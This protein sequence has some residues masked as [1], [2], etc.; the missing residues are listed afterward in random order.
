MLRLLRLITG[1]QVLLITALHL[2]RAGDS[3]S[4]VAASNPTAASTPLPAELQAELD[5]LARA[6][7]HPSASARASI[8]WRDNVLLSPFA[9]IERGFARG[10]LEAI[11]L[12]PMRD[13][14][15]FISFLNGDV[16][17]YFTPPSET[18]G[19]QQWSLHTEGR[20]QP[21]TAARLALKGATYLRDMVIDLSETEGS[22]VV[23]PTHVRGGYAIAATRLT[24]G[25]VQ[26]EPSVQVKRT[27]YR[28]YSGDYDEVRSGARLEWKPS[29]AFAISAAWFEGRRS[30]DERVEYNAGGR[31]LPG[32]HLRFRQR[33]AE[34]KVR[35]AW[36]LAGEWMLTGTAG[37]LENRDRASSYFDYDQ[38]RV[39]LELEW[40]RAR[41]QINLDGEAK[42]MDYLVQTVGAGIA[43]PARISDDYEV[44][45]RTEREL[46][47]RWTVFAEHRWERSRSNELEFRYR[48]NTVLAGVERNF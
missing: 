15:Q 34:L 19:E 29:T 23:A 46:D 6:T 16:L 5:A 27:D 44:T 28:E 45:L 33:D 10:E 12:R 35:T 11:L 7:W 43:P 38:K 8:G 42:R 14:W 26:L 25:R 40:D 32:T 3:S 24:L 18:R 36:S 21:I 37:Q 22:R 20:W 9:A 2:C 31:P 13:R 47:D 30:Y 39:R 41:W 1:A 4:G 17:R 48:A